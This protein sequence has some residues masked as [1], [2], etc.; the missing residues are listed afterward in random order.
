[1]KVLAT[2]A[3][4]FLG[5]HIAE[6]LAAGGHEVRLLLRPTSSRSFLQFPHE[7]ALGDIT[8]PGSLLGA[9][10]GVD[11]VIHTAGLVKARSEA[12]FHRVNEGGAA[13][14]VNAVQEANPALQRFTNLRF[15]QIDDDQLIA[16]L[17]ESPDGSHS[18]IVVVN[19]DPL[20]AHE[21]TLHVPP[22][23]VGVAD[24]TAYDVRDLLTGERYTWGERNYVRLDPMA[25]EPA[26][27]FRVERS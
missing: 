5:S 13:N 2:G 21:G 16:Y 27:I 26:H 19:L 20:A 4:G 18:V 15:L 25:G 23:A 7:V 22:D 14:L 1:M 6:Q 10:R 3:S 12:E 8:D 24:G 9:V 17:K 11:S